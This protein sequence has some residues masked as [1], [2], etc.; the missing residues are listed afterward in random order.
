MRMS[1]Y[2]Y[3]IHLTPAQRQELAQLIRRGNAPARTQTRARILLLSDQS[4][5]QQRPNQDIAE[6]VLCA[7]GT[8]VNV[9]RRFQEGGLRAALYDK[10]RPGAVPKVDGAVEAQ[11]TMLACSAPP[12]GRARW[13]L[14]LLAEKLIELG[15]VEYISHV[16]VRE[17][18]K[19]TICSPGASSPGA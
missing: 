4:Q 13:T 15:V 12:E 8:V 16:T 3:A 7:K 1:H 18:L 17:H 6:A 14:R 10:E 19:K 9:R 5:G 2:K 11:L